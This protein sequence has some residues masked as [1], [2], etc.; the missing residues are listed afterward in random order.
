MSLY[1]G[2]T[3][4]ENLAYRVVLS[5]GLMGGVIILILGLF[6]AST[7]ALISYSTIT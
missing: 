3:S 4:M 1:K 5:Y 2:E 6:N 7:V